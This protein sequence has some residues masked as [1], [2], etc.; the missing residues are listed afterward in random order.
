M[1]T[2]SLTRPSRSSTMR[3]R[4]TVLAHARS[5]HAHRRPA[6]LSTDARR[7]FLLRADLITAAPCSRRHAEQNMLIALNRDLPSTPLTRDG[8][9]TK[10]CSIY[11]LKWRC[12]QQGEGRVETNT[13]H[14]QR[15]E[16]RRSLWW[17]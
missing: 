13:F 9:L 12:T 14:P 7:Y 1:V 10:W 15:Q 3:A 4:W 17:L 11:S 8:L 5:P 16:Q 2:A 6:P